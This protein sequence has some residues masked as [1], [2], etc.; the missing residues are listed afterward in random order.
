MAVSVRTKSISLTREVIVWVE[1]VAEDQ[2]RSFSYM[3]NA[4]LDMERHRLSNKEAWRRALAV[5][6]TS[7]KA[8]KPKVANGDGS[9]A[10]K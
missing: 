6:P 2:D 10:V 8:R 4:V 9:E 3:V 1:E 5:K 7:R